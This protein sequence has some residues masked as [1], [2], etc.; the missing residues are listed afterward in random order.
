MDEPFYNLRVCRCA[1]GK[2]MP[3][4][5]NPDAQV[6]NIIRDARTYLALA[7]KNAA[8][9]TGATALQPETGPSAEGLIAYLDAK[10]PGA[11]ATTADEH[12]WYLTPAGLRVWVCIEDQV[13]ITQEA[14]AVGAPKPVSPPILI[15][16]ELQMA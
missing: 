15:S 4:N 1:N 9:P 2:T 8:H 3:S 10:W 6:E 11:A 5:G 16:L 7:T 12:Y 14:Q 13:V